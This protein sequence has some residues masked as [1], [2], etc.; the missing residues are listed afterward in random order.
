MT[1]RKTSTRADG[2]QT[3]QRILAAAGE[4]FAQ[5]GFAETTNKAIAAKAKVDLASINYHFGNRSGLYQRAL[6]TA[7]RQ[8]INIDDLHALQNQALAPEQ[9]LTQFIQLVCQRTLSEP[10]WYAQILA[11]EVLSPSSNLAVLIDEEIQP[12]MAI[13]KRLLSDVSGIPETAPELM[14]C[15]INLV[16]PCLMLLVTRNLSPNPL[17]MVHAMPP[18]EVIDHLSCYALAGLKA[19]GERYQQQQ[20]R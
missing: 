7:H 6:A 5:T 20:S 1:I 16:A 15:L 2:E 19:V 8:I 9:K 17:K 3:R 18:S 4:L 13:L 10:S 14:P 12:K 11:R